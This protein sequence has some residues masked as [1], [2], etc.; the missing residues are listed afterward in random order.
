MTDHRHS[1]RG[2]TPTC[3]L[4]LV[5]LVTVNGQPVAAKSEPTRATTAVAEQTASETRTLSEAQCQRSLR[6]D[7][8]LPRPLRPDIVAEQLHQTIE[9]T[10]EPELRDKLKAAYLQH[11]GCNTKETP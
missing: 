9:R 8:A 5:A 11:L 7:A 2:L 10:G 6:A 3:V 1:L 4:A